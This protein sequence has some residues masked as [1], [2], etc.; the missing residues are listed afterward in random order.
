MHRSIKDKALSDKAK[1]QQAEKS[2]LCHQK[3]LSSSV[4]D[5]GLLRCK[6]GSARSCLEVSESQKSSE[7]AIFQ[8]RVPLDS[9]KGWGGV[10]LD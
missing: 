1:C 3:V 2:F 6:P 5:K 10:G 7:Q 8:I 9:W 4:T